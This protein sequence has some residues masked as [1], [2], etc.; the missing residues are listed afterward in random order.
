MPTNAIIT[1]LQARSDTQ[2]IQVRVGRIWEAINRNNKTVLYTNVILMDQQDDHVLAIIRNN[3]RHLLL[4]QLKE[5]GVYN[6]SNFKVVPG[7]A[8][9]RSVDMDMSINFFYKTKIEETEDNQSIPQYKFELQPFDKVQ[10]LVGQIK[11]L[12]DVVGMVTSIGR[13]E[14]RTNGAEKMDVALTDSRNE[15]MIV[16]LWED[17]AYQFQESLQNTGQSPIFVVITG[18]LAK[19]F[20]GISQ[21][22]MT[23]KHNSFKGT[24]KASLLSTDA[25]KTYFDIDYKPLKD[26]KKALYDASAKS[27]VGLLPPTNVHFVTADEKSAKQLHIKDVLDMEIPPGKDQVRGL[28]TATITGIME[29]NGW[30]YNCCSKCARAV[31]PTEGKYFCAA[32]NDDN[33]TV[34]Q[35]YRVIAAIK[36][37]TGTTTVTLFNKEAEQLIGAPIQK[38]IKELT[39]GT[40]L[41]EIPPSVKNIVGKLCAFQI[42]INNYNITHGCEEYTVTRVSECSNAEAGSSDAVD[43][44][45]KDK[46]IRLG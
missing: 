46:R 18:L 19:K 5:Q 2:E 23:F 41:E 14:K 29:G 15:K 12:I 8:S 24:D 26:L 32:C 34:S 4:P 40:D 21:Q 36:D 27:G 30:L 10:G 45:H 22:I 28:C 1:A 37:D 42:K 16:T 39:E 11:N 9:Y 25:T 35:R 7:P 13:L 44:G 17:R 33:I 20:S 43:A 6:I 31:H 38:L 3:Q